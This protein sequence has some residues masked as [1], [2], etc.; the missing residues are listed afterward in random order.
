MEHNKKE[1]FEKIYWLFNIA[2]LFLYGMQFRGFPY[3]LSFVWLAVVSVIGIIWCKKNII[4]I[5]VI[6]LAIGFLSYSCIIGSDLKSA[7]IF[8]G[9]PVLAYLAG[10]ALGMQK[11]S[12]CTAETN[13]KALFLSLTLGTFACSLLQK[14]SRFFRFTEE[15]YSG[16][17]WFDFWDGGIRPATY[18]MFFAMMT[19]GCFCWALY[20]WKKK[21]ILSSFFLIFIV[22]ELAFFGWVETRTPF[23]IIAIVAGVGFAMLLWLNRNE[24]YVKKTLIFGVCLLCI[25][26]AA[27][28]IIW[29]GNLFNIQ[30]SFLGDILAHDGGIFGN[31]RFKAQRN[32]LMQLFD[33]PMGGKQMNIAGLKYAHNVWLDIAYTAG[34]IPFLFVAAYTILTFIECVKLIKSNEVSNEMKYLIIGIFVALHLDYSVEPVL[35]ANL[36]FWAMGTCVSGM[37]KGFRIRTQRVTDTYN[38]GE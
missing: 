11:Y 10:K 34:I 23:L 2:I 15:C 9:L 20:I 29:Y 27:M 1:I 14:Y 18:Y 22:I 36:V 33:Y 16:R 25:V 19:L 3:K 8:T 21:K 24:N 17:Y 28:S 26:M 32:V 31:I 12:F 13:S 35:D 6:L 38:R 30:N 37:I 5:P 7:I 4:D